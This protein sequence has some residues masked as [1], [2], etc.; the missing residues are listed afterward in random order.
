MDRPIFTSSYAPGVQI[1]L[2]ELLAKNAID[3]SDL[4]KA[5]ELIVSQGSDFLASDEFSLFI[6]EAQRYLI[7]SALA[8]ASSQENK[9]DY[10][11][12]ETSELKESSEKSSDE[13]SSFIYQI[14]LLSPKLREGLSMLEGLSATK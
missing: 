9:A 3:S 8:Y 11:E 14:T 7:T 5:Y 10:F 6:I 4:E 13:R 12:A 2:R 1:R